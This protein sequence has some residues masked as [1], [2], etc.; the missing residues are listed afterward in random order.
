MRRRHL[1]TC[2]GAGLLAMATGVHAQLTLTL[3][4]TEGVWNEPLGFTVAGSRCA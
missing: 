2:A 4:A 1:V 3:D